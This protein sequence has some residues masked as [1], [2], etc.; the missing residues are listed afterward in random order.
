MTK[1][2][3]SEHTLL[4]KC[5]RDTIAQFHARTGRNYHKVQLRNKWDS[6]R[7]KWIVWYNL[8]QH[9]IKLWWDNEKHTFIATLVC[10]QR[11]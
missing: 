9:T 1:G 2:E 4:K 7:K 11:N 8:F 10:M 3:H 6:L 5:L